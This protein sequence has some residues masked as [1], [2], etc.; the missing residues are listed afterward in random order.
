MSKQ[1]AGR[2]VMAILCALWAV[3]FAV[4]GLLA[5]VD[6]GPL[7]SHISQLGMLW[8]QYINPRT[9]TM[10][11]PEGDAIQPL[12]LFGLALAAAYASWGHATPVTS[13]RRFDVIHPI[14]AVVPLAFLAAAVALAATLSPSGYSLAAVLIL[15]F[16]ASWLSV[17]LMM[18]L[19]G[20]SAQGQAV[21][22]D[23]P[24]TPGG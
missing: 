5:L 8:D 12:V 16:A 22:Y 1:V 10:A 3:A 4:F 14:F 24:M 11:W 18:S 7:S 6:L 9:R 2:D 17:P 21:F 23:A 20:R 15:G 13:G 19:W